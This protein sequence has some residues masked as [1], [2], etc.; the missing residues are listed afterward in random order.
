ME[1]W[2]CIV[3]NKWAIDSEIE[4]GCL[5]LV[6]GYFLFIFVNGGYEC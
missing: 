6:V 4:D 1:L 2:L 3:Y 5:S